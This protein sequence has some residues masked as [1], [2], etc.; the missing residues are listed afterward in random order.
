MMHAR[1]TVVQRPQPVRKA[2][3]TGGGEEGPLTVGAVVRQP[4]L[5][6]E[7]CVRRRR[8]AVAL[9]HALQ[10]LAAAVQGARCARGCRAG[11]HPVADLSG[12]GRV[13]LGVSTCRL[14]AAARV[15]PPRAART[16]APPHA[17]QPLSWWRAVLAAGSSPR[18]PSP[19]SAPH[20]DG[21]VHE[22]VKM[23]V[24][25]KHL[26]RLWS[27]TEAKGAR[28]RPCGVKARALWP[29]PPLL[30]RG[31]LATGS[32]PSDNARR[33]PAGAPAHLLAD[34][35]DGLHCFAR[36]A[37]AQRLLAQQEAVHAVKH[38]VGNV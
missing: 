29:P 14:S 27:R 30:P 34:L 22:V 24:V 36:V 35:Q 15:A 11:R 23:V 12:S 21:S 33:R 7:V 17:A 6:R 28:I 13:G 3:P 26:L 5:L 19:H 9:V 25:V 1:Q 8:G 4:R 32:A 10:V 16:R 37:A 2:R 31:P 38:R 20:L 18:R